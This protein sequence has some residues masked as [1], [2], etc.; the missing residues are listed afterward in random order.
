MSELKP[1]LKAKLVF[2][3]FAREAEFVD[4]A[5]EMLVDLYG[6][7][8]FKGPLM[9]FD[10]TTY[11]EREFGAGLKRR[12]VGFA[13]LIDQSDLVD[14]KHQTQRIEGELSSNGKR[15]VNIDPGILTAERLVLATGK[16]YTH[17]IYL[18]KGVFADLTLIYSAGTFNPLPWTYPD[19]AAEDSVALWKQMRDAYMSRLK[20]GDET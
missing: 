8:D 20:Q 12:F 4:N 7:C 16:N 10:Y 19:Y 6:P 3:I 15:L 9:P 18:G 1:P 2:S 11:Y 5:L 13:R 14:V 17:R